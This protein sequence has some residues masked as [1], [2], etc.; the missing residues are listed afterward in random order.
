MQ[1]SDS[2]RI[3]WEG[4]MPRMMLQTFLANDL[5]DSVSKATRLSKYH[6]SPGGGDYWWGAKE[7]VRRIIAGGESYDQAVGSFANMSKPHQAKDNQELT[8]R[9]YQ[10]KLKN[11][12]VEPLHSEMPVAEVSGPQGKL[13]VKLEPNFAVKRKG[14]FE[15]YALWTFK[16][17]RLTSPVAGMGVHLLELALQHDDC[18]SW[19]FYLLDCGSLRRFGHSAVSSGT[20]AAATFALRTQ[21]E[22]LLNGKAA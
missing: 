6:A 5:A 14:V 8:Y 15:A 22:L 4:T 2:W 18:A 7:A 16:E 1:R 20:A 21:E 9:I 10:W 12:D 17:L 3:P 13:I 11:K 19:K